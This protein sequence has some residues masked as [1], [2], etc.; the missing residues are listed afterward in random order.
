MEFLQNNV[1]LILIIALGLLLL[2]LADLLGKTKQ[3]EKLDLELERK[4]IV[5]ANLKRSIQSGDTL[6]QKAFSKITLLEDEIRVLTKFKTTV[7]TALLP[8]IRFML[9]EGGIANNVKVKTITLNEKIIG[10]KATIR[11][12]IDDKYKEVDVTAEYIG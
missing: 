3:I 8:N 4:E 5:I 7:K 9:P 1:L 12:R 2:T 10:M 6:Q 11:R